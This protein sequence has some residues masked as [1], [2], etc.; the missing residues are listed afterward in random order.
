ML[1]SKVCLT[2]TK[3]DSLDTKGFCDS[4]YATDLDKRISVSGYVLQV[5]GNTVSWRSTLHQVVALSTIEAEY[6]ALSK[7]TNEGLWLRELSG[8]LGFKVDSFKMNC[9]PQSAIFLAKNAT[10]HN[11]TKHIATKIHFIKDV[12][13]E[14]LVKV[15][16]IHTTLNPT[17]MLTKCFF[18]TAFDKCLVTLKVTI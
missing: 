9:V 11:R 5:G 4:D 15:H 14:G 1:A 7:A 10:H 18:G 2:F 6:M 12:V 13:E 3:S 8:E 16:K 17:Y